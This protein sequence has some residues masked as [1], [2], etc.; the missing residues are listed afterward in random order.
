MYSQNKCKDFLVDTPLSI[1]LTMLSSDQSLSTL[2][3]L[4]KPIFPIDAVGVSTV[5]TS[6]NSA[7]LLSSLHW[8]AT[9][10]CL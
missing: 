4:S 2:H 5:S 1:Y 3:S 9:S 7:T 8:S 6:Y 10:H